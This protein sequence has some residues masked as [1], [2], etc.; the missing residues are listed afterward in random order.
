MGFL[1]WFCVVTVWLSGCCVPCWGVALVSS[2][3]YGAAITHKGLAGEA[4][5]VD[6]QLA[7]HATCFYLGMGLCQ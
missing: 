7:H 2:H 3:H 4:A 6:H 5:H 1:W